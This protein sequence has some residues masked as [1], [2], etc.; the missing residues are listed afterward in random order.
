MKVALI[1]V[2]LLLDACLLSGCCKKVLR[3]PPLP[4]SV[5]GW[6]QFKTNDGFHAIGEF[7]MKKGESVENGKFGLTLI[8]T[9][10]PINCTFRENDDNIVRAVL[11]IYDVQ[12]KRTL[13]DVELADGSTNRLINYKFPIEKYGL[14]TIFT[15]EI[16]TKDEWIWIELWD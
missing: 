10:P 8:K 11:R 5:R 2:I 16:N 9:V 1:I 3:A 15:Q 6:Q 4:P 14:D 7:V 13:V 12:S